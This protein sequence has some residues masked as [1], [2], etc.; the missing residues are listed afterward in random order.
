MKIKLEQ[1][2]QKSESTYN[3]NVVVDVSVDNLLHVRQIF[4]AVST[5]LKSCLK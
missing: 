1:K 3:W 4:V 5:Q 2:S